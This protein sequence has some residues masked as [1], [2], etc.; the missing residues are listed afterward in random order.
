MP[1]PRRRTLSDR[2]PILISRFDFQRF[3]VD[4]GGWLISH[5]FYAPT[6]VLPS[7]I[8]DSPAVYD[9]LEFVGDFGQPRT[10]RPDE[11]EVAEK[12]WKTK[13]SAE[14]RM[15][16]DFEANEDVEDDTKVCRRQNWMMM[17]NPSCNAVHELDLSYDFRPERAGLGDDQMFDSFYISQ[18]YWRDVWVI[19][20]VQQDVK[21]ILKMSRWKHD[22]DQEVFRYTAYDALVMERLT[23]SPR[24]VDIFGHCGFAVWVEAIP[25]EV[26]EV[27]VPGSGMISQSELHDE[28]EL[29]P[30]NEYDEE[31]KLN[32]A[33]TM[34]ESIADLHG[35]EDGLM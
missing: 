28:E 24:I 3:Q 22:Y 6:V 17:Y 19:H 34:A 27:M 15:T 18:G 21:S 12:F 29:Q 25:F 33:L 14:Y 10:T 26:E 35:F 8:V 9:N 30:Q 7:P 5:T 20:Q 1:W 32:I 23:K 11:E 16:S 13:L 2:L 31:E 4:I